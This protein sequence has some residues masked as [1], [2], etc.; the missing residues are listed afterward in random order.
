MYFI[1]TKQTHNEWEQTTR[2]QIQVNHDIFFSCP[3]QTRNELETNN[4]QRETGE[5]GR[6]SPLQTKS[7]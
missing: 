2:K 3:K 6:L 5:P 1:S 7:P 4:K